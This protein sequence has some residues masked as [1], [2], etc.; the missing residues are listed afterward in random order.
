MKVGEQRL[1]SELK[2]ILISIKSKSKVSIKKLSIGGSD[3][4]EWPEERLRAQGGPDYREC[5]ERWLGKAAGANLQADS[6][7]ERSTAV[8]QISEK[9]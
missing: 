5:A 6:L 8:M 2:V 1:L 9:C 3:I 4:A 7:L